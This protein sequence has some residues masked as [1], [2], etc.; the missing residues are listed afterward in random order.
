MNS[1][2]LWTQRKQSTN[3]CRRSNTTTITGPDGALKDIT[4]IGT[5]YYTGY[6]IT[7]EEKVVA[8]GLDNYSQLASTETGTKKK[9]LYI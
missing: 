5:G 3:K 4:S 7:S 1:M 6:A 2:G 8:W 9:H